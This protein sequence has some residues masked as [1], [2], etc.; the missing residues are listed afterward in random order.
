MVTSGISDFRTMARDSLARAEAELASNDPHR[1]RYAVLELRYALEALTYDQ[2]W[3]IKDEISPEKYK[4]WPPHD[5]L[6]MLAAIDPAICTTKTI[7]IGR[8]EAKGKPTSRENME[9]LGTHYAITWARILKIYNAFGSFLHSPTLQNMQSGNFPSFSK[10]QKHCVSAQKLI[11]QILSSSVRSTMGIFETLEQ[12]MDENCKRPVSRRMPSGKNVVDAQC[13]NCGAKYTVTLDPDG[14]SVW[15]IGKFEVECSSP[16]CHV[17]TVLWKHQAKQGAHWR[18]RGCGTHNGIALGVVKVEDQS[19][20][21]EG[22]I[23][24]TPAT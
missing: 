7:F 24:N 15:E 10:V 21:N 16:D 12:C 11:E 3:A 22:K 18:C 1:L 19:S 5:V 23:L 14:R 4:T 8:Q 13:F 17:K 2:A 9:L 20:K 6:R